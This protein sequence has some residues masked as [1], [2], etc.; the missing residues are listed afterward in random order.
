MQPP[1]NAGLEKRVVYPPLERGEHD[2]IEVGER[3]GLDG[4][5]VRGARDSTQRHKVLRSFQVSAPEGP[6]TAGAVIRFPVT[7][8]RAQPEA[9]I[10]TLR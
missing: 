8:F 7:N 2:D 9:V 5:P 1:R 3:T 10:K 6:E 4:S